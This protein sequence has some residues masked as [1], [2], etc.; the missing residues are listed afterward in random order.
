MAAGHDQGV[1][2]G[3]GADVHEAHRQFV[4][5]HDPG[6]Q[7]PGDDLAEEAVGLSVHGRILRARGT[8]G[9]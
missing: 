7:L 9:L 6:G 2:V 3:G 1:A 8:A 5:G 4:L